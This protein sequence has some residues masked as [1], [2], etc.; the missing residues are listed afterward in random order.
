MNRFHAP[1]W[2]FRLQPVFCRSS[3]NRCEVDLCINAVDVAAIGN[4]GWTVADM[5]LLPLILP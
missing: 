2:D 1:P 5:V 3:K 4:T